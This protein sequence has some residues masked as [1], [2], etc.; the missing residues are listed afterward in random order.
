[1]PPSPIQGLP[2]ISTK[3]AKLLH[4]ASLHNVKGFLGLTIQDDISEMLQ[5][6]DSNE[7]ETV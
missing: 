3:T 1:M 6:S 5:I 7:H 2:L 4:G